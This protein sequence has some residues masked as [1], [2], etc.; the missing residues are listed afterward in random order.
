MVMKGVGEMDSGGRGLTAKG[1][2]FIPQVLPKMTAI[3]LSMIC[4]QKRF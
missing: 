2:K 1:M 4:M 3:R